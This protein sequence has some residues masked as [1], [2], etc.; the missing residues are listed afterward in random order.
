MYN[1]E[2]IKISQQMHLTDSSFIINQN[3]DKTEY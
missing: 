3:A 2:E 1:T